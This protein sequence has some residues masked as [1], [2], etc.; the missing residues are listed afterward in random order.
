M[1]TVLAIGAGAAVLLAAAFPVGGAR[2]QGAPKTCTEAYLRC[3][4]RAPATQECEE[5][6]KWCLQTGT[7]ADPKTKEVSMDLRKR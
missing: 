1:H 5:E 4:A 6:R 7:F 3:K 2:A